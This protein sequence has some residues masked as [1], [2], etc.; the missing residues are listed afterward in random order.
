MG[1][2]SGEARADAEAHLTSALDGIRVVAEQYPE[3]RAS[4]SFQRLMAELSELEDQIQASRRIYNANVNAYNT[5]HPAV[6]ELARRRLEVHAARA[7]PARLAGRARR[8]CH[9]VLSG[10]RQR[11]RR[12]QR[13]VPG[14]TG[15]PGDDHRDRAG[16]L[17]R[18][19]RGRRLRRAAVRAARARRRRR[20]DRRRRLVARRPEGRE[21][22]LE[23]RRRLAR[24]RAVLRPD[25]A[26]DDDAAAARGRPPQLAPRA[27]GPARR[28]RADRAARAVPLRRPAREPERQGARHLGVV[29]LHDLPDRARRR[30]GAV[31]GRLPARAARAAE[32]ASATTGCAGGGSR[33]SSSRA[34]SSTTPTSCRSRRSRTT[35]G[36]ASCSTRRRSCGWPSTR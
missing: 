4:E 10:S 28:L 21:R 11:Q 23:A 3:L 32:P 7:V 5:K 13:V 2:G 19:A 35:G 27:D 31:P 12:A 30:D 25:R 20:G 8:P 14:D 33:R 15:P 1:A 36:C 16:R 9:R 22:V 26:R 29:P 6:P 34:P 18:A 17:G 24:L